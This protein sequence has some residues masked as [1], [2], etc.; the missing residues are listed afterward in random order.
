M[1]EKVIIKGIPCAVCIEVGDNQAIKLH[2][3]PV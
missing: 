2:T 3:F 1:I